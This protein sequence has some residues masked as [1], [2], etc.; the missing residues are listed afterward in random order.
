MIVEKVTI[1]NKQ[2]EYVTRICDECGKTDKNIKMS[3]VFRGSK[4]RKRK[5]D[6]CK[7]CSNS[8]KYK[9]SSSWARGEKSPLW[10]GGVTYYKNRKRIYAGHKNS[11]AIYI[12]ESRILMANLLSRPLTKMEIVHHVDFSKLNNKLNN[13]Y[14][15]KDSEV[16]IRCHSQVEYLGLTLLNSY[17]FFDHETFLYT[18][19]KLDQKIANNNLEWDELFCQ[20]RWKKKRNNGSSES[21][22]HEVCWDKSTKSRRAFHVIIAEKKIG[23]KLYYGECVHHIDGNPLNNNPYNLVVMTRKQHTTCHRSLQNNMAIFYKLGKIIFNKGR[24]CLSGGNAVG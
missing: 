20:R 5:I 3:I 18:T 16:H 22:Y 1:K 13:L 7:K 9:Y 4:R 23:R 19:E 11:Q 2:Y 6:L 24:Y 17:I 12:D 14:L 8:S 10:K 15:F 21:Q